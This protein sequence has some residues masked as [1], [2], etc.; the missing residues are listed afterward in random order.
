MFTVIQQ[1]MIN[2]LHDQL[3]ILRGIMMDNKIEV[4]AIMLENRLETPS[5]ESWSKAGDAISDKYNKK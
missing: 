1:K 5:L 3:D 4:Q 2:D